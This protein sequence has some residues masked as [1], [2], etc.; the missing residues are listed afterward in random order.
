M[1]GT[2]LAMVDPHASELQP[3]YRPRVTAV[4]LMLWSFAAMAAVSLIWISRVSEFLP[5]LSPAAHRTMPWIW[6][7]VALSGL[8]SLVLINPHRGIPWRIRAFAAIGCSAYVPMTWLV[9]WVTTRVD[10]MFVR[11]YAD[12]PP[13][14][15]QRSV[16]R[17]AI[18]CCVIVAAISLRP[19]A[20]LLVAR[21]LVMRTGRVDRQTLLTLATTMAIAMLGDLVQVAQQLVPS[22]PAEL[23]RSSG[24][25]MI[26]V[27]SLLFTIGLVGVCVDCVR[28]R[29]AIVM[30]P[31]SMSDLL[32]P[33]DAPRVGE[34][35]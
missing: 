7:C 35:R 33:D 13:H 3:I 5:V 17:L 29:H 18:E 32:G 20:R 15:L 23:C 10:P 31:L 30:P 34:A 28:L 26:A 25:A 8:G 11:P 4:G 19:A 2:I 16:L 1:R 21:S 22:L 14:L 9:W 6:W 27:G 12:T 24:V